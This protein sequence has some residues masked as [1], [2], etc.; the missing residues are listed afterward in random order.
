MRYI[1]Q[2]ARVYISYGHNRKD[3]IRLAVEDY[4]DA[5][6]DTMV[7]WG[8]GVIARINTLYGCHGCGEDTAYC[9][10]RVEA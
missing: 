8:E 7:V 10:C 6:R 4:K 9:E 2:L 5:H 1:I 3:A